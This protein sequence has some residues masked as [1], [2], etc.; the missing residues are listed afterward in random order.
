MLCLQL[1]V[2]EVDHQLSGVQGHESSGQGHAR[3]ND[4]SADPMNFDLDTYRRQVESIRNE[5]GHAW[6]SMFNQRQQAGSGR[7]SGVHTPSRDQFRNK[8]CFRVWSILM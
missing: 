6:L 1:T 3:R 2:A 7:A 5:G 8:V 4:L